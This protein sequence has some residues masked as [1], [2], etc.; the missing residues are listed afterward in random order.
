VELRSRTIHNMVSHHYFDENSDAA[1][2]PELIKTRFSTRIKPPLAP[3]SQLLRDAPPSG[4]LDYLLTVS[5]LEPRK[6]HLALLAA[7]EKLR[8]ER[9]PALKLLVVGSPGWQHREIV[10][11]FRP[12]M[13]RGDAFLLENVPSSDLRL[14]YKHARATVCPSY[15]EGFGFSGVEAMMSGGAVIASDI[16]AHREIYADAAQYFN[17]Y[18]VEDLFGA[19]QQV[20]MPA[21]SARRDEL[22]SKGAVV[23]QRYSHQTIRLQWRSF[24]ADDALLTR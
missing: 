9:C 8:F 22:I 23:A 12:W 20:I 3:P 14:L 7:W 19:I 2:V 16:A 21:N 11:K 10:R 5:T 6:N 1:R 15:A 4:S 18:S 17:P 24:L 13:E